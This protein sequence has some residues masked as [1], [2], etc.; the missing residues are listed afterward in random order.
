MLDPT[1]RKNGAGPE[2]RL[3]PG[4]AAPVPAAS[5]EYIDLARQAVYLNRELTW[6]AFNRRVLAEANDDRNPLLE[7]LKFLAITGSNLDE[8]FMKR[9]GGLKLQAVAG[10]PELTVDGRTPQEQIDA[11]NAWT[12]EFERERLQVERRLLDLL[13]ERDIRVLDW[14]E[15]STAERGELRDRYVRNIFPLITPLALDPAHPF[16][17]LSNLSLNLLVTGKAADRSDPVIARVKVPIGQGIPRLLRVRENCHLV[18]LEDI[19]GHNLDVLF[20][21]LNIA[22][23]EL[24][25]VT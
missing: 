19:M 8:F 11:C 22:S 5:Q 3:A 24:F 20:P 13:A 7:R 4:A 9:I 12:R 23:S 18:L 25:R 21:G 15:L 17:F 2:A 10:V 14:T 6:L 1:S 16:P